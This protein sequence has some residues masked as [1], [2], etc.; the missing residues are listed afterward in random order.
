VNTLTETQIEQLRQFNDCIVEHPQI[1]SIFNDFDEL[2]QNR[3]FQLDQQCM[4]LSG[5]AGVGKSHIINHYRKRV[6]AN[7][8]YSRSTIPILISRIS[9]GK[10]LEATLIQVLA[11][12]DLFGSEQ[13]KKRG[14]KTD[15]TKKLIES[16]IKAQV[17][18][19]II[20]EF[21]EL[22]EFKSRQERQHIA[23]ELKLI[24]EEAKVPIVLVGM[25]WAELIAEEPQWSSRLVRKR[26]LS[27][28]S[29]KND[30]NYFIRYIMGLANKMPFE[31]PPTL[32]DKQTA[33]AIFSACRGENRSLKHLLSESL[34]I[35]LLSNENLEIKHLALAFDKLELL[36]KEAQRQNKK[37]EGKEKSEDIV[38][39][40]PFN[41]SL[42]DIDISEVI[43]HSQYAPN[44]LDPEDILTGRFF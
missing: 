16:L 42:K 36:G 27:Y 34:K 21:Q 9:K 4:L 7:Q 10:G 20:N 6:L 3:L 29:L 40:N 26:K 22:I 30:K 37:K 13:R 1:K 38:I 15:L 44:A 14:Y 39:D 19:L 18:L 31:E 33:T 32:G 11:D 8:N 23:N 5:D 24:S 35:A 12:L 17:E 43:K 25:P 2:R 28:F 41:Q